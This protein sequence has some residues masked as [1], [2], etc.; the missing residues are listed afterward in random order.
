MQEG[1]SQD[2]DGATDLSKL[3]FQL[4]DEVLGIQCALRQLKNEHTGRACVKTISSMTT[5]SPLDSSG[6]WGNS[7]NSGSLVMNDQSNDTIPDL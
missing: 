3:N 1:S 6:T 2:L 5:E 4:L 7:S